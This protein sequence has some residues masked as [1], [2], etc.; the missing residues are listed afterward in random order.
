MFG[1]LKPFRRS[2]S[3]QSSFCGSCQALAR[4]GR[5]V[6]LL[7][8]YDMVFLHLLMAGLENAPEKRHPC[9][10][11]PFRQVPAREL[12]PSGSDWLASL[13]IL[14]LAAKCTDD[15]HDEGSRKAG[16]V[17]RALSKQVEWAGQ[18]VG[19]LAPLVADLPR[20]QRQ[21]EENP[22]PSLE[23]LALPI[24][25][26]LGRAFAQAARLAGRPELEPDFQHL[27]QAVALAIYLK[28]ALDDFEE[29]QR[30]GRFNALRATGTEHRRRRVLRIMARELERAR[31]ILERLGEEGRL[32]REILGQLQVE[33]TSSPRGLRPRP[34]GIID[35]VSCCLADPAACMICCDPSCCC[36]AGEVTQKAAEARPPKP[37]PPALHCPACGESLTRFSHEGIEVDEC[38][39][40]RGVWLDH[41]EL[42]RLARLRTP[43]KR[44]LTIR[45]L[46]EDLETRPEGTRPCP[47]C[48]DFLTVTPVQG[49]RLDLCPMCRGMWLD[50]GELNRL[51]R[52]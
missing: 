44:L 46:P 26:V 47:R 13:N 52:T 22:E 30:R 21:A 10:A 32:A 42:E 48:G 38:L 19:Q 35:C 33:P 17:L 49:I 4:R 23:G 39:C 43:P 45:V 31:R 8:T 27:G 6:G 25:R 51:L 11:L 2:A 40:C 24:C 37:S 36:I 7:T 29:D 12:S 15:L 9:T 14:L 16:W 20:A 1:N 50:Q 28:D 5:W 41:G 34:R 3:Y 18:R